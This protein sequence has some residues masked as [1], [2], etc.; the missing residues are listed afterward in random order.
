MQYL[1]DNG[2]MDAA[3][4]CESPFTDI[5]QLGREAVSPMAKVAVLVRGDI[6]A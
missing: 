6:R 5:N 4:L 2:V 1:T 3:R